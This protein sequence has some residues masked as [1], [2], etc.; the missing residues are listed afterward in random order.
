MQS[1]FPTIDVLANKIFCGVI[2]CEL[3]L[4]VIYWIDALTGSQF[5]TLHS[6]FDLDSE[7]NIP[8]WFSSAQLLCVALA[9]WSR[10]LCQPSRIHPSKTFFILAGCAALYVSA[11][12]TAQIHERVTWWMGRRYVDWL[13][14]LAV[15][16]FWLVMIAVAVLV[17]ICQLLAHDLIATWRDNR[18]LA[19]LAAFGIGIG[20]GGGMGVETIGYEI[21]H[22]PSTS[23]WYKAEVTLEEFMEMFG[24]SL[25]L[26]SALKF[27]AG[28]TIELACAKIQRRTP[29]RVSSAI[30]KAAQSA[31]GAHSR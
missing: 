13:P 14:A 7:A 1:S 27:N 18:R 4:V 28:D 11:D 20:L 25:I 26:F 3:I 9:F 5:E 30:I 6:L 23:L 22:G 12:E 24:A 17:A 2:V 16:N 19:L 8:A 15:K 29:T 10:A 31:S 21:F